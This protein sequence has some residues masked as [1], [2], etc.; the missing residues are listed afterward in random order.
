MK[1]LLLLTLSLIA[2][3]SYGLLAKSELPKPGIVKGK[4]VDKTTNEALPYVN[5]AKESLTPKYL[6]LLLVFGPVLGLLAL[7]HTKKKSA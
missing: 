2:L 3:N 1:K 4:V 6:F 5:L 7:F